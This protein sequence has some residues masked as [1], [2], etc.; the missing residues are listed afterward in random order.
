[1]SVGAVSVGAVSVRAKG[2]G[3]VLGIKVAKGDQIDG[4]HFQDQQLGLGYKG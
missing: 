2:V 4:S 1:M 3:G